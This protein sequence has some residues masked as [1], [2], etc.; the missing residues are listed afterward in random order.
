MHW[1]DDFNN[2]TMLLIAVRSFPLRKGLDGWRI[3]AGGRETGLVNITWND[4]EIEEATDLL[5]R[6]GDV[7]LGL[8]NGGMSEVAELE[9]KAEAAF[10]MMTDDDGTTIPAGDCP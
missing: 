9:R 10:S 4:S 8:N 6:V 5:V 3:D 2:L 1:L 7:V